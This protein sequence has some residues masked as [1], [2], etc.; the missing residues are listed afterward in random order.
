MKR[1]LLVCVCV[2]MASCGE[3]EE[4]SF[5]EYAEY[6]RAEVA[7][8]SAAAVSDHPLATAA[9]HKVL[10]NGGNAVDAAVTMAGVLAVVRPHMNG[11]GGDA[12]GLFY[13]PESQSIE[14][15][16]GSG[17][18]GE[19]AS[20]A[21][22]EDLGHDEMPQEGGPAV[23]VPGALSAWQQA[24]DRHG[25]ISLEE[26]LQPAIRYA[27]EGFPVSPTLYRDLEPILDELNEAGREIYAPSGEMTEV[28][29]LVKN[30]ALAE[31]L[32]EVAEN[33]AEAF[34]GGS[35]GEQLSEFVEEE[36]G[37]LRTDD[38]ANHE[39]TWGEA[40]S[41]PFRDKEVHVHPPNTQ[42]I[43]LLLQ[44]VMSEEFDL[45]EM[46]HNSAEYIHTLV[47]LKKLAFADR[48]RWV[49]DFERDPAPLD[50][51]LDE[52]YLADRAGE[53]G[54]Q[55]AESVEPGF[56]AS[57]QEEAAT[58]NGDTVY[59][60]VVDEDGNAVSWI[61][62]LFSSFGSKLVEPETGIVLQNRGG[63]FT[64]EEDHPN[65][66][67]GGKRPFH[68]LSPSMVTNADGELEMTLGTPGGDGQTQ[69]KTQVLHNVFAFGMH[70]QEAV[71]AARYRSYSGTDLALENRVPLQVRDELR[72]K[73]HEL[74]ISQGWQ[75][76]F[77]GA[78]MIWIDR[79]NGVL[80]TGADPRREAAGIAY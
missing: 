76:A 80:R 9:G 72:A 65:V 67:E 50:E 28:G 31:T 54:N 13:D 74:D 79:E 10:Q 1:F 5:T 44:L 62:S 29:Q 55:A 38:F 73:G 33:G 7:G 77:G 23:T 56:D 16:N 66:I 53:V 75:A 46:G 61:Q 49:A 20:V 40:V 32:T 2:V 27:E 68:T 57:P 17:R 42:G 24:L 34:Y 6:N 11:I 58:G 60:M 69:T 14:A 52:E 26:A 36:G 37:H 47:E 4:E 15:L 35:I 30:P 78:Q 12:F 21:F 48:N 70:P 3:T 18:A 64:L 51:L 39:A 22:I 19:E 45:E 63:G 59:L 43:T 8:T 25:T 41:A 71:E